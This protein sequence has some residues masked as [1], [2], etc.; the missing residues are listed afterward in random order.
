MHHKAQGAQ[1][2]DP[3][4]VSARRDAKSKKARAME[5]EKAQ[6]QL[7]REAV[8]AKQ[9]KKSSFF[10]HLIKK[11]ENGELLLEDDTPIGGDQSAAAATAPPEPY[12]P[13]LSPP[14]SPPP[15][16]PPIGLRSPLPEDME[17]EERLLREMGWVP[18]EE[19]PVPVLAEEEIADVRVKIILSKQAQ[20]ARHEGV[21]LS[22]DVDVK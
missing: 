4:T 17:D 1:A 10:Q 16:S 8:A 13:P 22:I 15:S 19:D 12:S 7:L 14:L 3:A 2:T 5:S 6:A 9:P 11:E 20:R 18:D 21:P